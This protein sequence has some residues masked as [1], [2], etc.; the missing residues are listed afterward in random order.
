VNQVDYLGQAGALNYTT[1]D[2]TAGECGGF[3]WTIHWKVKKAKSNSSI[4]QHTQWS[5]SVFFCPPMQSPVYLNHGLGGF[6]PNL[7]SS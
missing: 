6:D 4:V 7:F 1:K 5:F 2:K 3:N